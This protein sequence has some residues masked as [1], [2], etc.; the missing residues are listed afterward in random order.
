MIEYI[1]NTNEGKYVTYL[2]RQKIKTFGWGPKTNKNVHVAFKV[3]ES[4]S[5]TFLPC[6]FVKYILLSLT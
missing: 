6:T 2:L 4:L 3:N 5:C 1:L